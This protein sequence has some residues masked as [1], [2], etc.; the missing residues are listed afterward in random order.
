MGSSNAPT[1]GTDALPHDRGSLALDHDA[2]VTGLPAGHALG[3]YVIDQTI[4]RGGS[5][6]VYAAHHRAL[7]QRVA[8]KVLRDEYAMSPV[9]VTRFMREAQAV[10]RIGHPN[11]VT[12]IEFAR[13]ST[14]PS[15]T[16]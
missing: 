8:I 15:L 7:G 6:I 13:E 3:S 10:N 4:G 12:I 5:G 1:P 16:T 9:A 11:I 2:P 14:R